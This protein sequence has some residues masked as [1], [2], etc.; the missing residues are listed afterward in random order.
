MPRA[1]KPEKWD[2]RLPVVVLPEE[3]ERVNEELGMWLRTHLQGRRNTPRFLIPRSGSTNTFRDRDLLILARA[4]MKAQEWSSQGIEYRS[5]R[6]KFQQELRDNLKKRFSRF[7]V[8][9]R[10]DYVDSC[11][12]EFEVE[13]LAE[14]G[15]RI[16]AAIENSIDTDL[17]VP[18]DFEKFI[19]HAAHENITFGKVLKELQEPRPGGVEC[20]PWL[21]EPVMK[22]RIIRLSD[23]VPSSSVSEVVLGQLEHSVR[24]GRGAQGDEREAGKHLPQREAPTEAVGELGQVARQMLGAEMVVGAMKGALDIAQNRVDPS[25]RGMLGALRSTSGHERLVNAPGVF[26]GVKAAQGVGHHDGAGLKVAP[27]PGRDLV[28]SKPTNTAQAHP[29]RPALLGELHGGHERRL[30]RRTPSAL[31][32]AALPAPVRIIELH[33]PAQRAACRRAPSSPASAC[34]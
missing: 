5:L 18:E 26:H 20:I 32:A 33:P 3:P 24:H 8:L 4:G 17:F 12:C 27:R 16:P 29:H 15:A 28:A 22:D 31:S 1:K 23:Y 25:E 34:A 7:A 6:R 14:E 19:L 13:S 11:N 10:W 2:Q 30:S 9:R 21:G